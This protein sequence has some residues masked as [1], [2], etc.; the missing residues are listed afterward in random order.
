M[1]KPYILVVEDE[2]ALS[3]LVKYNLEKDG[4]EVAQAFDG[5]EALDMVEKRIPDLI[6][7][8]WMLPSLSGIEVCRELR[9][10]EYTKAL[11]VIM[12]TARS[13][14]TDKLKGFSSGA[15][16]YITKP[17]SP[18][19]LGARIR[20]VLKRANPALLEAEV[21]YGGIRADNNRKAIFVGPRRLDLSPLE[22]NLLHYMLSRPAKVHS[23]DMLLRNV[24][25]G[26]DEVEERTV[27]VCIR[28]IRAELEVVQPGLEDLI[29]TVR[30]EG[31]ILEK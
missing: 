29:K 20:S 25:E 11:P 4:F 7:L 27:D 2:E 21:S 28:R 31:Y 23:R 26:N 3:L 12:L 5:Q 30:G 10:L 16:D 15:D 13:Q 24:W 6:V 18:K 1:N 19:E 14:E 9:S 17:F 8:D 22:Y